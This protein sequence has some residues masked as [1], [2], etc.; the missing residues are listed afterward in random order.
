MERDLEERSEPQDHRQGGLGM[1][2]AFLG[3]NGEL[4]TLNTQQ[5]TRL[6]T[7]HS[8]DVGREQGLG[9]AGDV[10]G[11]MAK[12]G[13]GKGEGNDKAPRKGHKARPRRTATRGTPRRGR[14]QQKQQQSSAQQAAANA[15]SR[16]YRDCATTG[17]VDA[18]AASMRQRGTAACSSAAQ[19]TAAET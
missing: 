2:L 17:G 8:G 9:G 5:Y 3:G 16:T 1:V 12:A 11:R 19:T 18:A 7:V 14:W 4:G 10:K 13:A 6:N 15:Y